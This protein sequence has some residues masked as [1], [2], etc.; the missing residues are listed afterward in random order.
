MKR[1]RVNEK[2]RVIKEEHIKMLV[3]CNLFPFNQFTTLSFE[4]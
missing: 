3:S 2:Y 4:F 1:A